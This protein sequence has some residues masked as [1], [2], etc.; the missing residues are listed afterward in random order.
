MSFDIVSFT[1]GLLITSCFFVL[2]IFIVVATK[3]IVVSI[4]EKFN[5]LF[6][7]CEKAPPVKKKRKPRVKVRTI[8]INPDEVDRVQFKKTS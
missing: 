2:S 4:K 1:L 6:S 5:N 8:S 7:P 3:F